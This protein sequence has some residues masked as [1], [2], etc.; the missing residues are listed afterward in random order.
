V[1]L[2]HSAALAAACLIVPLKAGAQTATD[3][4]DVER[5]ALDYVEGFYEGD[6]LKLARSVRPEIVKFGFYRARGDSAYTGEAMAYAE[7]FDYARRVRENHRQRGPEVPRSVTVLDVLNQ[8][9]AA[10]VT[11]WWGSDYLHLARYGG[12]WMIVQVLWQ[13]APPAAAR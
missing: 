9:A 3:R 4:R 8:T 5:A 12:R 1:K 13:D 11:A 7:F 6:S 10:K 2:S